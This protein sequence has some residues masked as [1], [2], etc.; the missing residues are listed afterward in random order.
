METG[1]GAIRSIG[2]GGTLLNTPQTAYFPVSVDAGEVKRDGHPACASGPDGH[3]RDADMTRR[4]AYNAT[5]V[6]RIPAA[7][8]IAANPE[9]SGALG[10]RP[11]ASRTVLRPRAP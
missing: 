7:V 6:P 9:Y 8:T 3:P 4:S 1:R 11:R 2:H 5:G 10:Q